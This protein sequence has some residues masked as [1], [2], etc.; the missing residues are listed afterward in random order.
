MIDLLE[1]VEQVPSLDDALHTQEAMTSAPVE[2]TL[3]EAKEL[4]ARAVKEKGDNFVYQPIRTSGHPQCAYFTPEDGAPSCLVG[5]VLAYKGLTHEDLDATNS[6][7][8]E[9][10]DLVEEGHIRVDNET[11]ALLT[12]AQVEQDQGQTWGRAV[13][14]ALATY[15]ESAGAYESVGYDDPAEDYWF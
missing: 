14:E 11:L 3:D 8:T 15:E 12:V 9:V 10:Q 2:I 5:H 1:I 6:G 4:L 13:E 7:V